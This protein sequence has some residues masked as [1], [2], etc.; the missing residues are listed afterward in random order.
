MQ[1]LRKSLLVCCLASYRRGSSA[2]LAALGLRVPFIPP[3][4]GLHLPT[5]RQPV[6]LMVLIMSLWPTSVCGALS[7]LISL[8]ATPTEF[9]STQPVLAKWGGA[10]QEGE[11]CRAESTQRC[12]AVFCGCFLGLMPHGPAGPGAQGS[13][14]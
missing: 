7:T 6:D 10:G 11:S 3:Q 1:K 5:G 2:L 9:S 14:L 8:L 13:P 12:G 4:P